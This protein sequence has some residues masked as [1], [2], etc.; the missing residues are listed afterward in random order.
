MESLLLN[1][2]C[3]NLIGIYCFWSY[4]QLRN[5]ILLVSTSIRTLKGNHAT[6]FARANTAADCQVVG[7]WQFSARS[8]Q[9]AEGISRMHKQNFAMQPTAWPTTSEEAW[10]FDENLHAPGRASTAPHGQTE[11]FYLGSSSANADDPPIR[12][13]DV[14]S[15]HSKTVSGRQSVGP[16]TMETLYLQWWVPVLPI[17]Q[18]RSGLGAT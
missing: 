13:A 9:D 17:P 6:K 16:Q 5:E 4:F 18:W 14:N 15:N 7:K 3:V 10:R 8:S 1:G 12:E 2:I 11:P